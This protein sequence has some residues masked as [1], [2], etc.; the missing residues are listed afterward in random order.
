MSM[1]LRVKQLTPGRYGDWDNYVDNMPN[2]SIY[3]HTQWINIIEKNLKQRCVFLFV[4]QADAQIVGVLPLVRLKSPL[5]GQ[6]FV[7]MPYFNYGGVL[8]DNEKAKALLIAEAV[9]ISEKSQADYLQFR[10]TD[11]SGIDSF[12]AKTDK[13][14]MILDL[15]ESAEALGK[16]IGSKR[17]SQIKRP[18]RENVKSV[19]GQEELLDDFYQVFCTNMRDL[20]TPVYAKSFFR[21]M[22]KTFDKQASIC[23][24]YWDEK[25]VSTGF[26]IRYK[27]RMEIPWASTVRYANKISINMYLYWEILCWSIEQGCKQFDFGRS[28][29]DA[30]TYKFKKQWGALPQQCY[31]YNWAPE[32]KEIP[33]LSP[34]NSKFDLAIT[35]W[36]KLPLWV[37]K[38]IGPAL[39]RNLP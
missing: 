30:G 1:D 26:L 10:E 22:L 23:V 39:V 14:N 2:A 19:F 20:G 17:R 33:N 36:Q 16:S 12:V 25:P 31:W 35:L 28:S 32:G 18:Q 11:E 24:V 5:F 7:S 38:L 15:P 4:E 29:V 21:A 13:V 37:T 6:F 34:S 3:H 9:K 8:S 27:D